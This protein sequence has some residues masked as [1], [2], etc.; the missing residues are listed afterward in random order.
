MLTFKCL[1]F[2]LKIYQCQL[3]SEKYIFVVTANILF[4][5]YTLIFHILLSKICHVIFNYINAISINIGG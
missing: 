1:H 4:V 3:E 5:G 2:L